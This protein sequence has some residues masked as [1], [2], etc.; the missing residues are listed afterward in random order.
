M[1]LSR[2]QSAFIESIKVSEDKDALIQHV[3]VLLIYQ[4]W[5]IW[6]FLIN[7][8]SSDIGFSP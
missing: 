2:K 1:S 6:H 5:H 4:F 7:L 8:T 3:P